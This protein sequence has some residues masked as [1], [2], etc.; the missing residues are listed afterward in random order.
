MLEKGRGVV[1]SSL[2]EPP[3]RLRADDPRLLGRYRL[4]GRLGTGGMGVVY[5]ACDPA[6]AMPR[7]VA[8]KVIMPELTEDPT[9]SARFRRE[10]AAARRVRPFCTA[11]VLDA[12]LDHPPLF[13]VTEYVPGPTVRQVVAE[14]GALRGADLDALAVG[15]ATALTAIHAEGIVH[16]D[17]KPANVLLSPIGPRVIDFGIARNTDSSTRLTA[18]EGSVGT[19]SF[20]PPETFRHQPVGPPG[21][22]FGWG[23]LIAYAASGHPPFGSGTLAEI[24]YRVV[25][26]DPSLDGLQGPLHDLVARALDKDPERRPTAQALLD[27]LVSRRAPGVRGVPTEPGGLRQ[28]PRPR[29]LPSLHAHRPLV[30]AAA[31]V[32][33]AIAATAGLTR[34]LLDGLERPSVREVAAGEDL[35]IPPRPLEQVLPA[36]A[37][38]QKEYGWTQGEQSRS[39]DGTYTV[40]TTSGYLVFFSGPTVGVLPERL[41]VTARARFAST[42]ESGQVG[43]YC[44]GRGFDGGYAFTVRRDGAVTLYKADGGSRFPLATGISPGLGETYHTIQGLCWV[45]PGATRLIM[46]VDGRK[47]ADVT[48]T[49]APHAS[50]AVGVL[51]GHDP[52]DSPD[53]VAVFSEFSLTRA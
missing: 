19:P 5:L 34:G 3:E 32:L 52:P 51:V 27:E 38:P 33:L 41:L 36:T 23:A 26:L 30:A 37:F 20:M 1:S 45:S 4:L 46:W 10:V 28:R 22:V 29:S 31:A 21:D 49:D 13:V 48:D 2:P 14:R 6:A 8:V 50:G 18:A 24:A 40:S 35:D 7:P 44:L 42:R 43:V 53:T 11:P 17:L 47:V 12:R 16:R 25:H 9:F 15:V 39:E